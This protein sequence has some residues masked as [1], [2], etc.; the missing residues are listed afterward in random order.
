MATPSTPNDLINTDGRPLQL[1]GVD[2]E[3]QRQLRAPAGGIRITPALRF[4][5]GQPFG[6]TFT[7]RRGAN[8]IN[9]GTQRILTEPIDAQRQ[10]D[11]VILDIRTEKSFNLATGRRVGLFFDVYNLTNADAAQNINWGSGSTFG[12]PVRSSPPTIARS[13]RSSTGKARRWKAKGWGATRP[14]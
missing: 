3:D 13:A 7:G 9:Y 4:Q 14:L 11:I 12:C 5:Q 10:D 8:G 2:R 6:R 1:L